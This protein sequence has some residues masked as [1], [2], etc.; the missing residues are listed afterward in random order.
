MKFIYNFLYRYFRAPWDIGPREELVSLVKEGKIKPCKAIDL[1]SG[2]A[3]NCIYLAEHGFD[4]TGVD[5]SPAA[6]QKGR[7]MTH[8]SEVHVNFIVDD[9]TNLQ[10]V[11]GTFDFLVDYGTFDDLDPKGR[12]L[13]INNILPLTQT[14]TKFLFFC[15]EWPLR[16]W[17]RLMMRIPIFGAMSLEPGEVLHRFGKFFDIEQIKVEKYNFKLIPRVVTYLM[18]RK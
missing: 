12:V 6:I 1:G 4:V 14:G 10:H 13:Y 11:K 2:T 5:Y 15:F 9:L 8:Q 18:T 17:D 16:W 7:T 3:S